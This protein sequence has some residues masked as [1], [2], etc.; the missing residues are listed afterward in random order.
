M[1]KVRPFHCLQ[2]S[3]RTLFF[4][5]LLAT[6]SS[7]VS[8]Q[9][10]DPTNSPTENLSALRR[11][12]VIVTTFDEQDKPLLQGSGF[13]VKADCVVTNLHV[14]ADA[15]RVRI[16][17]FAGKT[18]LVQSVLARNDKDDLALLQVDASAANEILE[19]EETAPVEG[20]SITVL[21]NPRGSPWT[22]THGQIGLLWAFGGFSGRIQISAA[23]FPGSSGAPVINEKGKVIGVAAMHIQG[24]KDLNF[25][26]PAE[27]LRSLLDN[28]TNLASSRLTL[29]K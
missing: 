7:I 2:G 13:F 18:T 3:V 5:A 21:S 26:V 15:A 11:A 29:L 25:A 1:A 12:V 27:S 17:T 19:L 4:L 22:I 10:S 28:S 9:A 6:P 16:T 24:D 23:I 20:E 14:I 8:A